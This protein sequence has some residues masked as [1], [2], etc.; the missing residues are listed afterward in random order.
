MADPAGQ[1]EPIEYDRQ[2]NYIMEPKQLE[3]GKPRGKCRKWLLRIS[4][5]LNPRTGKY[6][7]KTKTF[8][9]T[10][11]EA[12]AAL[13]EFEHEVENQSSNAPGRKLTFEQLAAEYV[14]HRL[15]MRQIEKS[16][17]NKIEGLLD[18]LSRHIG[19][20]PASKLEPYMIQNAVKAMLSGDSAS[21]KPLSGT[22]VNMALQTASTMYNLYAIPQGLASRNPFDNVERPRVDTEERD[23]LTKEQQDFLVEKCPPTDRHHVAVIEALLAGLRRSECVD[24]KWKHA[25]LIDGIIMLPDTKAHGRKLTAIPIQ[26]SLI[27]YLLDWKE[28]Q[29]RQMK[30]YGVIQNDEHTVCANELGDPLDPKVLGRWW[31]RNRK[32]LGCEGVHFHD[33]RHTFATESAK[34]LP[35]K[36]IQLLLRQKDERVSMRIYT[37]VNTDDLEEAVAKLNAK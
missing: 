15:T 9:G 37:H 33:L 11:R 2:V 32:K 25:N 7:E 21:G 6:G 28:E 16:T 3:P 18:A 22:Y 17:A 24:L 5:G 20:M 27:K 4:T 35:P 36:V 31:Q 30:K 8:S 26:Q 19:K 34:I 1:K 23:P 10:Y 13:A 29:A 12:K 14:P